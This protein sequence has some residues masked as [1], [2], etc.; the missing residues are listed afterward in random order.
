MKIDEKADAW[1]EDERT[2]TLYQVIGSLIFGI[3]SLVPTAW[4]PLPEPPA[5]LS[6]GGEG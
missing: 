6:A 4:R 5:M 3:G 2:S 1:L